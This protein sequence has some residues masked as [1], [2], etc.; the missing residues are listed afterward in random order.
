M[1]FR[2]AANAAASPDD[3][4]LAQ[5]AAEIHTPSVDAL[6]ADGILLDRHYG[7]P[8]CSPSRCALQTGRLPVHVNTANS[9]PG[10]SN[11][12]DPVSGFQGIPRNM[13]GVAAQL[14]AVGCKSRARQ[15]SDFRL[16][17]AHPSLR[18]P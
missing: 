15:F 8:I 7:A 9:D 17:A 5:A 1:G 16:K 13:T 2:R 11:P 10:I 18:P 12:A 14:K 3:P 6:V 4:L